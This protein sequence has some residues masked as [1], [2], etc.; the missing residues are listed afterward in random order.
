MTTHTLTHAHA[1]TCTHTDLMT[2]SDI[3]EHGL[4]VFIILITFES[5]LITTTHVDTTNV[6]IQCFAGTLDLTESSQT[7]T[8]LN[9]KHST[10]IQ[11]INRKVNW[12]LGLL[13]FFFIIFRGNIK[14]FIFHKQGKFRFGYFEW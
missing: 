6:I 14:L 11:L 12:P 10:N 13:T 5:H 1:R 3:A 7:T 4:D 8:L 9:N 2:K